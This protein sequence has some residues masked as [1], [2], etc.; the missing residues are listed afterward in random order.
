MGSRKSRPDSLEA[1]PPA[2][3]IEAPDV[4]TEDATAAMRFVR[5]CGRA[6][7]NPREALAV[8][9][10]G[11][12]LLAEEWQRVVHI[13]AAG[14][15][16]PLVFLQ[17]TRAGLL[18]TMPTDVAAALADGYRQ[19]LVT[20]HSLL[21]QQQELLSAL[22]A[23]GI[24]AIVLKGLSLAVR[25]YRQLGLR[26]TSDV[27]LLVRRSDLQRADQVLRELGYQTQGGRP[28]IWNDGDLSYTSPK[29]NK[30]ELHWELT[31]RP[32]YRIG[33]SAER[34]W[35]RTQTLDVAN[36]PMRVLSTSDELRFLCVHC[37]AG[38]HLRPGGPRLIWLMDIAQVVRTLPASWDWPAFVDEMIALRLAAPVYQALSRCQVYLD[39]ELPPNALDR[40]RDVSTTQAERDAWHASQRD[41]FSTATLRAL[42]SA[43]SNV[44]Q[45]IAFLKGVVLPGSVWLREQYGREKGHQLPLWR[46][47]VLY[48]SRVLK[49][50]PELVGT[51]KRR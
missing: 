45:L 23:R 33:L 50:L 27:D 42:L 39:V 47:Y 10:A 40:L 49:R 15:M 1:A 36:K 22:E 8:H 14:G 20:N 26:P 29:G 41:A 21:R 13:A 30:L 5:L 38:H 24:Q 4:Q 9:E 25:Y 46:A 31:H 12:A 18:Q 44:T 34:A 48:L 3:R 35:A 6:T 37:T 28:T 43:A 16:V 11:A 7:L 51:R 2:R 17:A 32:S 19:T